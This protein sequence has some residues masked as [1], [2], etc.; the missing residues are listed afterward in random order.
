MAKKKKRGFPSK[1][2]P[3]CGKTIHARKFKCPHCNHDFG[4]AD[5]YATPAPAAEAAPVAAATVEAPA[6]AAN[7]I[8]LEQIRAVGQM[9]KTIGKFRCLHEMLG[10]IREVGGLKEFRDLLETM[11]ITES[12][13][14]K[15]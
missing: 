4:L 13:E 3:K 6:K 1:Q 5:K 15:P 2:C 7:A 12:G 11:E 9:V 8:T 10:V 14:A